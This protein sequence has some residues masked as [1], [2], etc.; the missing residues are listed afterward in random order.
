[1]AFCRGRQKLLPDTV[2]NGKK[3]GHK[4]VNQLLD[5]LVERGEEEPETRVGKKLNIDF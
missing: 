5:G 2:E 4:K 3:A 1:M